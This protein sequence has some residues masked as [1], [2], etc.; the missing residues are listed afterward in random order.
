MATRR[1]II[2]ID[3]ELCT[4]CGEC[5][6]NCPEG[7][8]QIIDGKARLVSDLFCDGLGACVG[9]CPEG[10]MAVEEREAEPYDERKVMEN[11]VTQGPNTIK[12]HLHHLREHGAMEYFREAVAFLNERGIHLPATPAAAPRQCPGSLARSLRERSDA[13]SEPAGEETSG[14]VQSHLA[15]WPIQLKLMPVSAPYLEGARLL[16][17]ADCT[18]FSLG[19]FHRRL[20]Q[21]RVLAIACPKLDDAEF[22][23]EK[24]GE[25][26]KQ[27]RIESLEVVHM[28]VPCCF[29]LV[30]IARAAV[31]DAGVDTPLT[32]IQV[33]V[34]GG[35]QEPEREQV[36]A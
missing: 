15:N 32:T 29:G 17:A 6:P 19:D 11:V 10:A 16:L 9:E 35:V 23:R 18:A 20:L 5:I 3:E 4:G 28:E 27:N 13:Q 34:R 33:G 2:R 31:A 12:A 1:K 30:Q 26:L 24:L 8:L 7:A 36:N 25:I 14:P 22:Y 21:G